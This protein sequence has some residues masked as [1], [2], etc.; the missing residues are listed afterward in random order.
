MTQ[1]K[2]SNKEIMELATC[3]TTFTEPLILVEDFP[4]WNEDTGRKNEDTE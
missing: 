2:L 1:S 4:V 3:A